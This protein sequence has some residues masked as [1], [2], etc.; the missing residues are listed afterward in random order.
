MRCQPVFIMWWIYLFILNTGGISM[1]AFLDISAVS[2]HCFCS[3]LL[4]FSHKV[5]QV[6]CTE[7]GNTERHKILCRD[8]CLIP[9][10]WVYWYSCGKKFITCWWVTT[11]DCLLP[12]LT[13]LASCDCD[14]LWLRTTADAPPAPISGCPNDSSQ[15]ELFHFTFLLVIT[16]LMFMTRT[17]VW[18]CDVA[19][20]VS[21]PSAMHCFLIFFLL[22]ILAACFLLQATVQEKSW[23]KKKYQYFSQ[24]VACCFTIQDIWHLEFSFWGIFAFMWQHRED[25][26]D[27]K[28]HRATLSKGFQTWTQ[29]PVFQLYSIWAPAQPA[30]STGTQ[31]IFLFT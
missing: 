29:A 12:A 11:C 15:Q 25:R 20:P 14:W 1:W 19:P 24:L 7:N 31:W 9:I 21:S 10:K 28:E 30:S 16:F 2:T 13:L 17:N 3:S 5:T 18:H 22:G 8:E 4:S 6:R 26:K 23:E 27:G